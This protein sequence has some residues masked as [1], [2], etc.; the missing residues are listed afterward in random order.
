MLKNRSSQFVPSAAE[1]LAT[2]FI[3]MN[4]YHF[5]SNTTIRERLVFK[6]GAYFSIIHAVEDFS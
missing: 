1:K 2:L 4:G 5:F 6:F 3:T